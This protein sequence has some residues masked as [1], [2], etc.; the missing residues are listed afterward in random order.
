MLKHLIEAYLQYYPSPVQVGISYIVD[1]DLGL[2]QYS[3]PFS[4]YRPSHN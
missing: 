4:E 3:E 1:L 2:L